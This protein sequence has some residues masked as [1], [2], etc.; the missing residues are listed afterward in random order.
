M[1]LRVTSLRAFAYHTRFWATG[2]AVRAG[3]RSSIDRMLRP[4]IVGDVPHAS[5][6]DIVSFIEMTGGNVEDYRLPNGGLLTPHGWFGAWAPQELSRALLAAQLPLNLTQVV[7]AGASIRIRRL[8][9]VGEP[10]RFVATVE[11]VVRTGKRVR[12]EQDLVTTTARGETLTE[13][14]VSLLLPGGRRPWTD[15]SRR[16]E[17]V[18]ATAQLLATH[19]LQSGEG[20]RFAKL[21]GDFNPVHWLTPYA[22]HLGLEGTVAH[23]FDLCARLGHAAVASLADHQPHRVR[24]FEVRFRQPVVLPA[25]VSIFAG[26]STTTDSGARRFPLWIAVDQ[27]SPANAVAYVE[28]DS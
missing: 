23:G 25:R 24:F 27:Q 5:V 28:V 13:H 8:P 11:T 9:E 7:H 19:E 21:S 12:I 22:R 3:L 14:A 4:R 1:T 2:V 20:W 16:Q 26:S 6:H 18:P 15:K 10:M 17:S